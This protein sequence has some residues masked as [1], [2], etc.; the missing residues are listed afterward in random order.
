MRVLIV[1]DNENFIKVMGYLL[2]PY[3]AEITAVRSMSALVTETESD[4][5]QLIF[6]DLYLPDSDMTQTLAY[7]PTLRERHPGSVIVAISGTFEIEEALQR[8]DRAGL[9]GF[10]P[11]QDVVTM[12]LGAALAAAIKVQKQPDESYTE[13]A[14]RCLKMQRLF[15]E[16]ASKDKLP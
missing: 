9:D 11:K 3:Q 2:E 10:V 13:H 7:V 4:G 15:A 1:E 6:L 14:M 5:Y 12:G 16:Q 8:C